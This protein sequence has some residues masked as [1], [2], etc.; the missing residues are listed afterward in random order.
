M[1]HAIAALS[2]RLI[3]HFFSLSRISEIDLGR[4][5]CGSSSDGRPFPEGIPRLQ[6]A[7]VHSNNA[8]EQ[9]VR[10]MEQR[11]I[12]TYSDGRS[13]SP[14]MRLTALDVSGLTHEP[15]SCEPSAAVTVADEEVAVWDRFVRLLLTTAR[16]L[17][18]IV[19]PR[20]CA[21]PLL[22]TVTEALDTRHKTGYPVL[23]CLRFA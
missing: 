19:L 18:R 13:L 2:P 5:V 10:A 21:I 20:W 12:P 9:L 6:L 23:R 16:H 1:G 14:D 4:L 8:V 3:S 17:D 11:P 22:S 7:G 15:P